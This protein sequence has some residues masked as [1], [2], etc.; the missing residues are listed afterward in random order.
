MSQDKQAFIDDILSR[1]SLDQKVGQCITFEFAGTRVDWHAYDKILRHQVGGLR[2]TPHIYTEEPY[3]TRLVG[4]AEEQRLSPYAPPEVYA[5]VL[6]RL[7]EIALSREPAIPLHISSDQEGDWSQ[8][9]ARGGVHLFPSAMGMSATNDADWVYRAYR[10]VARQQRAVGI[11]Q[12]HTPCLDVNIEPKNPE[13]CTR[14]FGDDPQRCIEF[15]L[16]QLRA[17]RDEGLIATGKHF[18]GRGDSAVDVHFAVDVNRTD[19]KRL[20]EVELAPYRALIA[21]GLPCVMTAHTIYPALDADEMPAS[22]SRRI[23]TDLL[24]EQMGFEGVITTDAMGMGGVMKKFATYGQACAAAIAAGADLVL[25]KCDASRRDEVFETVK[26]YVQDGKIPMGELDAHVRRILSLKFDYGLFAQSF[27]EADRAVEPIRDPASVT[28][29]KQTALKAA[30]LV[31][32]EAGLLPLSPDM[33]V[34]VIEQRYPLYQN[35]ADDYWWHSNMLQEFAREHA[36]TVFECETD[37]KVSDEQAQRVLATADKA[38]VVIALSFF[39]R[40]NPTNSELVAELIRRG[41]KVILVAATPYENICLP[42]VQTL[43]VTFAAVPRSL[44]AAAE[45]IYGRAR[46]GGTWPLKHYRLKGV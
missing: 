5:R 38:D 45:I 6:N 16:A 14:S 33:P 23:T 25:S 22:V 7:Q 3:G 10:L 13:I 21:E 36:R 46:P 32:D 26:Q 40:G 18:P 37:L 28:L 42:Q 9:Y 8:D 30:V 39:W 2:V 15:G 1:M 29:C 44:E 43:V 11:R 34:L 35:K 27:V 19:R 17:F 4:G 41:K 12:L 20:E 31:R 24:R